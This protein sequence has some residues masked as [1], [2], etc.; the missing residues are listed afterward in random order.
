MPLFIGFSLLPLFDFNGMAIGVTR[1]NGLVE[2]KVSW[3]IHNHAGI[4][5]ERPG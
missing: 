1:R 3:M 5:P 2:P 4:T